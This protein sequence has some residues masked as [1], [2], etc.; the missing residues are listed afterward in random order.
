[1]LC[2]EVGDGD[3]FSGWMVREG[4]SGVYTSLDEITA[5]EHSRMST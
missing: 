3:G 5:S 2:D 4:D 1:M